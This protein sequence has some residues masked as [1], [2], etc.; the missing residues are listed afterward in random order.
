M[1]RKLRSLIFKKKLI[2]ESSSRVEYLSTVLAHRENG[3]REELSQRY[4]F[5]FFLPYQGLLFK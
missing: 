2:I 1:K 3:G 4:E 5:F